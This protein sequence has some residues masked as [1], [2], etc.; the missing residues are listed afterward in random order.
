MSRLDKFTPEQIIAGFTFLLRKEFA[1]YEIHCFDEFTPEQIVKGYTRLMETCEPELAI[2]MAQV[3]I[4]S[5]IN[6]LET[7]A[8]TIKQWCIDVKS[9]ETTFSVGLNLENRL[10]TTNVNEDD[11]PEILVKAFLESLT[12]VR[13]WDRY[14]LYVAQLK[15]E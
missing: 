8:A 15:H 9:Q 13:N 11:T 3:N 5:E 7:I 10:T 14:Q 4:A 6:S 1:E 2:L 12:R